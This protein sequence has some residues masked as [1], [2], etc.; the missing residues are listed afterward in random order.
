M[1]VPVN[2][3]SESSLSL[4]CLVQEQNYLQ[5][6]AGFLSHWNLSLPTSEKTGRLSVSRAFSIFHPSSGSKGKIK[7]KKGRIWD[8]PSSMSDSEGGDFTV[9]CYSSKGQLISYVVAP[10]LLSVPP[11]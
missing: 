2:R 9:G 1:K 4:D 8:T 7:I 3:E 5:G 10:D 11:P 6:L